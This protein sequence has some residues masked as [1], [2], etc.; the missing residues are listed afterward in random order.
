MPWKQVNLQEQRIGF[1]IRARMA[2]RRMTALCREFGISRDTGYRWL[3]RYEQVASVMELCE[4]S[5]RPHHSPTQTTSEIEEKVVQLRQQY[6]W[7]A[8]KLVTL[9]ESRD[10]LQLKAWT[11][12]RILRRHGLIEARQSHRPALLRFERAA[13]N[14]LWQMDGKGQYG[15]DGGW[16]YPL[17]ILDDHSRFAVGLYALPRWQSARIWSCLLHSFARYGMPEAFLIDHGVPWWSNTNGHGLTQFAVAL[18]EQGIDL[19]Y[20]RPY[21][22][23]TRGKIERLHRTL[24]EAV[25]FKGR[26][27]QFAAW[28]ELLEQFRTEYNHIR[29]HEA[30]AM[31]PPATRY[32]SSPRQYAAHPRRWTYP[33]GALVSGLNTQGCLDYQGHRWFVCEALAGKQ[34]RLEKLDQR[35]LVSFRHLYV[36]ELFLTQGHSQALVLKAPEN[37]G[38]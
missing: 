5:R 15:V 18:I 11:A 37:G 38:C 7:G 13:P 8:R 32:R 1:V 10:R 16:C 21:H 22:P 20:G 28:P 35:L 6:G 36:R 34:V 19:L 27:N 31:Q 9:L 17:T 33:P 4:V 30:L 12:H 26:P 2:G 29:P 14:E 3:R 23:Q 24:D 25:R